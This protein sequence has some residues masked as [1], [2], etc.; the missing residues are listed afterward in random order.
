[1]SFVSTKGRYHVALAGNG[2][3]LQGAPDRLAYNMQQAPVFGNR[4]AQG[5]R[6]YADFTF[7]WFWTQTNWAAGYKQDPRWADDGKFFDS[8]GIDPVSKPSSIIL[9]PVTDNSHV[10]PNSKAFIAHDTSTI[11]GGVGLVIVGRNDTDDHMQAI[12]AGTGSTYWQDTATTSGNTE[13]INCASTFDERVIWFGCNTVGSGASTLKNSISAGTVFDVGTFTHSIYSMVPYREGDGF[14]LFTSDGL[15]FFDSVAV[16]FTQKLAKYPYQNAAGAGGLLGGVG[17]QTVFITN[18]IYFALENNLNGSSQLWAYDI[19]SSAFVHIWDFEAGAPP[20]QMREYNLN[21][22]LFGT[23]QYTG[24]L[25]IWKYSP[26]IST[27]TTVGSMVRLAEI[28]RYGDTSALAGTPTADDGG[29]YF[30]LSINGAAN[31]IWRINEN[32]YIYGG[33]IIPA[34]YATFINILASSGDGGVT[35]IKSNFFSL[36]TNQWDFYLHLPP[37]AFQPTGYLT[38]S[39]FD[40]NIPGI[41]KLFYQLTLNF[42]TLI[43]GQ[44]LEVQYCTDS[45]ITAASTFT[46]LGTAS[47]ATDGGISTKDFYWNGQLISKFMTLKL[48]LNASGSDTPSINDYSVKYIPFVNYTKQWTINVNAGDEVEGLDGQPM[49]KPGRELR[50]LLEASW[51]SKS[52]LDY[53]DFDYAS[54]KLTA[55][56]AVGD[57]TITVDNADDFPE[58]GRIRIDTEEMLYTGKTATTFTG[59]T[60]GARETRIATHSSTTMVSNA[61][62]VIIVDMSSRIPIAL[63]DK[64]LEYT[65]Q[66]TLREA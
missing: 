25:D 13:Q 21:L 53:Q 45:V 50:A 38:S 52:I 33:I 51:W 5:D 65:V 43:T 37:N 40:G 55:N 62:R 60:R 6:T 4:F 20:M 15:Y 59:V 36:T 61:Y 34:A 22:Y 42:N 30:A 24:R 19:A 44:S 39:T 12:T 32:D 64:R 17:K 7:W 66:L 14:F 23:N 2:M 63:E 58:Q 47:F 54:C 57:T 29:L 41:D 8:M 48:I 49:G 31:Q 28:G 9:A 18:R 27:V 56:V 46:S 35:I 16:T 26:S 10:A 11:S 1:M 3:M